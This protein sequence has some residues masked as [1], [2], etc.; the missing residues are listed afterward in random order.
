[1]KIL[2]CDDQFWVVKTLIELIQ[3]KGGHE[4]TF[5]DH[6]DKALTELEKGRP[7]LLITDF[8][9]PGLNGAELARQA[10]ALHPGLPVLLVSGAPPEGE[11]ALP[12]DIITFRP[13]GWRGLLGDIERLTERRTT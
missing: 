13:C 6:P 7:G 10:K 9:M 12:F 5:V 11:D 1:M 8:N 2:W 4:V 3:T